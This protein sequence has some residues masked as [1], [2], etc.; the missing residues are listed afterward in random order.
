[1]LFVWSGLDLSEGGEVLWAYGDV[2]VLTP[3][4]GHLLP[5]LCCP[6]RGEVRVSCELTS[7]R[8]LGS[9]ASTPVVPYMVH[10]LHLVSPLYLITLLY[11]IEYERQLKKAKEKI[12]PARASL[13][14]LGI[15][16]QMAIGFLGN[17]KP[18]PRM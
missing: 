14:G 15:S 8:E 17:K 13:R 1:M 7:V 4:A 11:T 9:T 18:S 6:C 12:P 5:L 2:G 10:Y 16:P 3:L